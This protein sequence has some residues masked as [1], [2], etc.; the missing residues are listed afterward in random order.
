MPRRWLWITIALAWGQWTHLAAAQQPA[1]SADTRLR[2]AEAFVERSDLYLHQSALRRGMTGYGLTVVSGTAVEKFDVTIVSVLRNFSGPHHDVILCELSGKPLE[3]T[4]VSEGMSGSPVF[5]RDPA[6]GRDKM[7]G[8]VAYS[9]PLQKEAVCGVQPI[10]QMLATEGVPLGGA[11]AEPATRPSRAS[12]GA[13]SD[14]GFLRAVLSPEKIDFVRLA[15]PMRLRDPQPSHAEPRLAPLVTPVMVGGASSR[16]LALAEKIFAGTGL[17]PVQAGGVGQAEARAAA[18]VKLAPGMAVSI[19]LVSGDADWTAVG[20]VTEVIG[21]HVLALGHSCFGE[22]EV[23]LPMGPAY[24]HTVVSSIRSSFKVGSTLKITGALLQDEYTAVGGQVGREARM[25]PMTVKVKWPHGEQTFRYKLCRHRWL[26][27]VLGSLMIADSVNVNRDLPEQHT[28]DY[29]V[30]IDFERLGR[31][32][33]ANRTS[34]SY[35][36]PIRSDVSRPLAALMNTS[37]GEPDFPK[38][39]DVS[40]TV[41]PVQQTAEILSFELDRNS[42]KPGQTVRGRATLLPFRAERITR[43][44]SVKLPDDV[45]DG[46]YTL[47]VCDASDAVSALQQEMPHRFTPRTMEQ[48]FEAICQVV[49][50]R[51]DRLYVRLPLRDGGVAVKKNELEHAPASLAQILAQAAP[52]DTKPYRRSLVLDFPAGYVLSG[53]A[54]AS[55]TVEERPKR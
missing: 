35:E 16:T 11:G 7:I 28:I 26:T 10:A 33:A 44:V 29:S 34:T 36:V 38:S 52:I 46:Q 22:G 49:G 50:P 41:Q 18:D 19:P 48:L 8:A 51:M 27:A 1:Q 6:D 23:E 40:L 4:G 30:D 31:Y 47:T 21:E 54:Q 2:R 37:L 14:P 17:V 25:V 15:L 53:S 5:V 55:F 20:T 45:P 12:S 13:G 43:D 39:I 9:W 32:H 3:K 42:Y 24:V